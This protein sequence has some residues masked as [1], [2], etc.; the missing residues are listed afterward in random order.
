MAVTV[1][2]IIPAYNSGSRIA[3]CLDACLGQEGVSD[4]DYEVI[5][6]DN[7]S[8]DRTRD[9]VKEY[10]EKYANITLETEDKKS[11]YAARN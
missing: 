5:V 3:N 7:G 8:T 6:V 10:T 4:I 1:S 2:I 9:V 11:S